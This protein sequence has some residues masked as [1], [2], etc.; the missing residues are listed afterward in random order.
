MISTIDLWL[1]VLLSAVLVFI[2]SSV[3]HM[4]LPLHKG[5]YCKVPDEEA[6]LET[7]R[8]KGIQPAEYMFPFAG[9]MKE[10]G[11]PEMIEKQN[12]GPVGLLTIM[13]NGPPAMVKSLVQWFVCTLVVGVF[14]AYSS[15]LGL[16]RGA[17][18]LVV[19]RMTATI[20][21]VEPTG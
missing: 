16:S 17:E 20:A 3:M 11:S 6:V 21:I 15:A 14:V 2:V 13:Q 10:L 7:L 4:S 19:F 12:R 18:S 5:D 8:S 1:P 9:S